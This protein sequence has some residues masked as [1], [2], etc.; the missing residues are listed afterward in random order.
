MGTVLILAGI[1]MILMVFPFNTNDML[2]NEFKGDLTGLLWTILG[3]ILIAIGA[4]M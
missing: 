1:F 4:S 2:V 3:L